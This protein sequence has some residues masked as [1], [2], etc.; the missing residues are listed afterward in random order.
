M[1]RGTNRARAAAITTAPKAKQLFPKNPKS[2]NPKYFSTS[3]LL[4]KNVF[5]PL[6][7][8]NLALCIAPQRASANTRMKKVLTFV[9]AKK[10]RAWKTNGAMSFNGTWLG[11]L[12]WQIQ[13]HLQAQLFWCKHSQG[14]FF[15]VELCDQIVLADV[16]LFFRRYWCCE[17]LIQ[18]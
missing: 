3:K 5:R 13:R 10:T 11:R 15:A 17:I 6:D 12:D 18:L 4:E 7:L 14:T 8:L 16:Y 1:F 9:N 2:H